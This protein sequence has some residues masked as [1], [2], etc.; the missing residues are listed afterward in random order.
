MRIFKE[1]NKIIIQM[2]Q[3]DVLFN[4][5][6]REDA[7]IFID[8]SVKDD[9]QLILPIPNENLGMIA[10]LLDEEYKELSEM[11]MKKIKEFQTKRSEN[12]YN[13]GGI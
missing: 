13:M 9:V 4:N 10:G 2:L 3:T 8:A 7:L 5:S 11:I 1:D 12:M 6:E